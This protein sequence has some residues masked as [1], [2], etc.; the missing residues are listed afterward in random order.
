MI[1]NT[2]WHSNCP[3]ENYLNY[4]DRIPEFCPYCNAEFRFVHQCLIPEDSEI[5]NERH[6]R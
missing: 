4:K 5:I 1:Q 6:C 2:I 3:H